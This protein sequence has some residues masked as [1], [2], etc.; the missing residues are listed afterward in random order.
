M[1]GLLA[2]LSPHEEIALRKIG[3]T[4]GEPL[5]PERVRRLLQLELIDWDGLRWVL[6][7]PGRRRC[8]SLVSD[9]DAGSVEARLATAFGRMS[10]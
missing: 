5:E 8:D 9:S 10:T 3:F 1:R 4:S 2:P 7:E 6:T